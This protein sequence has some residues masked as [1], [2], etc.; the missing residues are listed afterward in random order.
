MLT[1]V[2]AFSSWP[3]APALPLSDEGREETD[4]IQIRNIDGLNPVKA[5]VNT[6][7]FGSVDGEAFVGSS[8]LS[9]NIVITVCPNPDWKTWTYESLRRLLYQYFMPKRAVRLVFYSDDMV[10]VEIN[11]IVEDVSV[12][13]F[14][15]DPEL[16]VSIICPYPYFTALD[17]T[18]VAGQ[19][20]R[21][22]GVITPINY[23]GNVE[24][25][26][27]VEVTY[28]SGVNPGS[29]G[30]QVGDPT[31][32]HAN[33][34]LANIITPTKYFE[35]SSVPLE[36]Y[37]RGVATDTG[38]ITNMLSNIQ[39]GSSWPILLPGDNDFSVITD[40]GVQDWRLV[41]YERF[42]GL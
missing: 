4:L 7:P 10:P 2:K 30:I 41:Y 39:I 19:S 23:K 42:G 33:V 1:E 35:L 8:V 20:I 9:R 17:P 32:T 27:Y 40:V 6:S 28:T 16:L 21:A 29:V 25:G 24:S 13:Q 36:K 12:N 3:S 5:S 11:G 22:G 34:I 37:V 14:S 31:L 15:K 18:V 26:L 38:L